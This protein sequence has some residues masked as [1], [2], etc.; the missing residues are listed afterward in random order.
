[1][2]FLNQDT[3]S[4]IY[5]GI[6]NIQGRDFL[7]NSRGDYTLG[8]KM[9]L[10]NVFAYSADELN[11][12]QEALASAIGNLNKEILIQKIDITYSD[13]GEY[14]PKNRSFAE[15]EEQ[16]FWNE[17]KILRLESYLL[18][19]FQAE[20]RVTRRYVDSLAETF[21]T[22]VENQKKGIFNYKHYSETEI[23]KFLNTIREFFEIL[24]TGFN[25]NHKWAASE[26][27]AI[28]LKKLVQGVYFNGDFKDKN[29]LIENDIQ[30]TN[31]GLISGKSNISI[32]N[33]TNDGL[34]D[35]VYTYINDGKYKVRDGFLPVGMLHDLYFNINKKLIVNSYFWNLDQRQIK[36]K[37]S[38]KARLQRNLSIGSKKN[39]L[40][41]EAIDKFLTEVEANEYDKIVNF[42]QSYLL[43][44]DAS[45]QEEVLN[46]PTT[47]K[48]ILTTGMRMKIATNENSLMRKF[49]TYAPG[50]GSD[51][52][53]EE[54]C[55]LLGK[56]ATKLVNYEA[57]EKTATTG[58]LLGDRKTGE[59]IMV[60]IYQN[61][62]KNFGVFGPPGTGKSVLNNSKLYQM[63]TYGCD[64]II[65]D[66][67]YSYKNLCEYFGGKYIEMSIENPLQIN[68]FRIFKYNST[69]KIYSID[70]NNEE[71]VDEMNFIVNLFM[72]CW[73]GANNVKYENAEMSY[74]T[75][76]II[77]Y[78]ARV[79]KLQI[80]P[81]FTDFYDNIKN[82][83][84][85]DT[86]G[87]YK[88]GL[89]T[90][91]IENFM[92]SMSA[93]RKGAMYGILFDT[94]ENTKLADNRFLI[95]EFQKI[96]ENVQLFPINYFI[97][98]M[99]V[100]EK[101]L[102]R[103]N[104]AKPFYFVI[105]EMHILLKGKYGNTINFIEYCVRT[106]RKWGGAFGFATQ[107]LSDVANNEKLLDV[108]MSNVPL[109]YFKKH[110]EDQRQYIQEKMALANN[111]INLMFSMQDQY[112]EIFVKN[113]RYYKVYKIDLC[114]F[115]YWLFTTNA[116]DKNKLE[117]ERKKG[118]SLEVAIK[119]IISQK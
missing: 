115:K 12:L 10:P 90:F 79:N 47:I 11:H 105:D 114:P 103:K 53:S 77:D 31:Q 66:L 116:D 37:L 102:N 96:E 88:V 23:L 52:A 49:I 27:N 42:H 15:L 93:F 63:L 24:S 80:A 14:S 39:K 9:S 81:T 20:P 60:D 106:V 36:D 6:E 86:T 85:E 72:I 74:I 78:M 70:L 108:I 118:F 13:R 99:M 82:I 48:K 54:R 17:K 109:M 112:T 119:N 46:A 16:R 65:C 38:A 71:S 21:K 2:N 100:R 67:G 57:N 75:R 51:I 64:V 44:S 30:E 68:P 45:N 73:K 55:T 95:F 5:L 34:P 32:Y 111:E 87:F 110:P 97:L 83:I 1:M 62:N 91:N 98:T 58:I 8:F 76:L 50:N 19:T 56:Y 29:T 94:V 7:I 28:D 69:T 61:T 40:Y 59:P 35:H 92:V 26:M 18:F 3:I 107:N 33:I 117:A 4:Q 101:L 43:Y 113:G 41:S 89:D 22:I 84:N 104:K 25:D